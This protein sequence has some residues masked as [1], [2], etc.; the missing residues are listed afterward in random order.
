MGSHEEFLELCAAATAG[1]LSADEQA[2]LDSHLAVCRECRRARSEYESAMRAAVST[3]AQ[4]LAPTGITASDSWS[5]EKAEKR[6][7]KWL[8]GEQKQP[9]PAKSKDGRSEELTPGRRFAY[10][11]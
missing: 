9:Q 11:P 6:F 1:E 10:S 8:D 7:F 2:R 5:A 4:E 3:L